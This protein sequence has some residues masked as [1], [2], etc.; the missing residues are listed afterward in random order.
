MEALG[1]CPGSSE[2]ATEFSEILGEVAVI[3]TDRVFHSAWG[4][5]M[6]LGGPPTSSS[7]LGGESLV[8]IA[9]AIAEATTTEWVNTI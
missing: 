8:P 7:I 2:L 9:M 6:S 3:I 1:L 4:V 5:L